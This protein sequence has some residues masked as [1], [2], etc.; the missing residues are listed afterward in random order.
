MRPELRKRFK[1]EK[2][3][4]MCSP[5]K[6]FMWK[7]CE[8][9]HVCWHCYYMY[10]SNWQTGEGMDVWRVGTYPGGKSGSLIW[11]LMMRAESYRIC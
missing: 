11:V 2:W 6:N 7:A 9:L 1:K 10:M 8:N 5:K 3:M 4:W